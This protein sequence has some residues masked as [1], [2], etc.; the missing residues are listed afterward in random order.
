MAHV[1]DQL[2]LYDSLAEA[3]VRCSMRAMSLN[4]EQIVVELADFERAKEA[5]IGIIV[6]D[7]VSVRVVKHFCGR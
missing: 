6:R 3:G 5:V 7:K 2:R 4:T 1:R